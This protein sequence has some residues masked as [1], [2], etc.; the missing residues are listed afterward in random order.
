MIL[1]VKNK[2]R[3]LME[4]TSV[5]MHQDCIELVSGKF[6]IAVTTKVGPRVIGGYIGDSENIFRV[7]PVQ[8]IPGCDTGFILYGGHRLWHSPEMAVRSYAPDNE[9]VKAVETD[10]GVEFSSGVE[11]STGIEKSITIEP[12]GD[13]KFQLTHRLINRNLWDIDVAPWALSVMAPGGQAI[14]PQHRDLDANPFAP[15]RSLVFWPY[16][17]P[18]DPRL[19]LGDEYLFLRQDSQAEA[20]LKIGFN[21]EDGWCAYVNNGTALVKY[22]THHVDAEY[23]DNGC[24]VESYSC[25]DFCELETVAPLYNLA[26]GEMAEHVEIWHALENLPAIVSQQDVTDSLL[27]KLDLD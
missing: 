16:S 24:S 14:I 11:P 1:S 13:E 26:P 12:L 23:P 27:P 7:M 5:E 10:T 6:R 3:I 9:P 19:T 22:F 4:K 25:A 21:A 8:P 2:E 17:N 18:Q 15:D 20:P